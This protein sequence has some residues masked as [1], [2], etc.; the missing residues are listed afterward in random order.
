MWSTVSNNLRPDGHIDS[1]SKLQ[2]LAIGLCYKLKLKY[3]PAVVLSMVE[4]S[5]VARGLN[6]LQKQQQHLELQ[7]KTSQVE[8]KRCYEWFTRTFCSIP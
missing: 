1:T 5:D 6:E 4:N 8:Y 3:R 7:A 2:S